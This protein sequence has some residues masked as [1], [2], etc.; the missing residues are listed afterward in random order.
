MF[1]LI[2]KIKEIFVFINQLFDFDFNFDGFLK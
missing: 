1:E 2:K